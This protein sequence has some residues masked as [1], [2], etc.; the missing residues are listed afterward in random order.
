MQDERQRAVLAG[1]KGWS[2]HRQILPGEHAEVV[3]LV[4]DVQDARVSRKTGRLR[5]T[6]L[7]GR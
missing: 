3:E 2:A 7:T 6:T 4:D 1:W 5:A